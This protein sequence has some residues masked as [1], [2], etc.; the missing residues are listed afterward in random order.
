MEQR[1]VK[2]IC[3]LLVVFKI[4]KERI[5][6]ELN[7]IKESLEKPFPYGDTYKIQKDSKMN[8]RKILL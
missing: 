1:L 3:N 2:S 6:D 4:D 7:E 5:F 8:F